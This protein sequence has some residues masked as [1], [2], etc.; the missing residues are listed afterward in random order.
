MNLRDLQE[1]IEKLI[2]A[3]KQELEDRIAHVERMY[4]LNQEFSLCFCCDWMSFYENY[5]EFNPEEYIGLD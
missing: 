3:Y 5:S 1:D 2:L 4:R